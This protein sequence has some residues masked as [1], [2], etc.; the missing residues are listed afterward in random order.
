[1]SAIVEES[2][3]TMTENAAKDPIRDDSSISEFTSETTLS[4]ESFNFADYEDK[5]SE[6]GSLDDEMS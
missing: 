6:G 5:A 1:M 2:K 4:D 3:D